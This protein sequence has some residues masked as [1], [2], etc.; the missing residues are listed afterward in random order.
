MTSLLR[1]SAS[2]SLENGCSKDTG[3]SRTPSGCSVMSLTSSSIL[4][5]PISENELE[6]E[7]KELK[8]SS[9]PLPHLGQNIAPVDAEN[10]ASHNTDND[11]NNSDRSNI[12]NGLC[13]GSAADSEDSDDDNDKIIVC[14]KPENY[15]A[16]SECSS[17]LSQNRLRCEL[18]SEQSRDP[19]ATSSKG[20]VPQE[21]GHLENSD[22]D[23]NRFGA[24][25]ANAC[26]S[27]ALKL[28][29]SLHNRFES[30]HSTTVVST[31]DQLSVAVP[32]PTSVSCDDVG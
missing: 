18:D 7:D 14:E 17:D 9:A 27:T 28:K 21:N 29:N 5:E 15:E 26:T 12:R 32:N 19:S 31:G 6:T 16:D 10:T 24:S 3:H 25:L 1:A 8:R 2:I 23:N 30:F 20:H 4:S 22:L 13:D 11:N